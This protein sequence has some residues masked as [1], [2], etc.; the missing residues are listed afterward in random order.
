MDSHRLVRYIIAKIW[1]K[2][3]TYR[4]TILAVSDEKKRII[5]TIQYS[6]LLNAQFHDHRK[7][8]LTIYVCNV[9]IFSHFSVWNATCDCTQLYLLSILILKQHRFT[10]IGLQYCLRAIIDS[11]SCNTQQNIFLII[12]FYFL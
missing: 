3:W 9:L 1:F 7:L 11:N 12:K 10:K 2:C 5:N 8:M 6:Y 4:R